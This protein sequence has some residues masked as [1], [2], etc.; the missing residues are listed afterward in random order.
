M[1]V[2]TDA[3]QDRARARFDN[4]SA[5]RAYLIA[6]PIFRPETTSI[7]RERAYRGQLS[8][9]AARDVLEATLS[10]TVAI[11]SDTPDLQRTAFALASQF[12][13]P[14]AYDAQYLALAQL[15]GC[16]LWTGDQHLV[17]SLQGDLPWVKWVGDYSP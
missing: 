3:L 13:H 17:N 4:W 16:E 2:L 12:N 8:A 5:E 15:A 1:L 9:D 11:S 14:K 10:W 6:P 7:V